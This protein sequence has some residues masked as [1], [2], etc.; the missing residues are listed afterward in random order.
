MTEIVNDREDMR[1][2]YHGG[3]GHSTRS[4][5]PFTVVAF[6]KVQRNKFTRS[7]NA[8]RPKNAVGTFFAAFCA[9][10]GFASKTALEIEYAPRPV[11]TT[12]IYANDDLDL[13]HK[14]MTGTCP[15]QIG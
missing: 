14:Y 13:N 7:S 15:P 8:F 4:S 11:T 1:R 2:V 9:H 6:S 10:N 5:N 12:L 3:F